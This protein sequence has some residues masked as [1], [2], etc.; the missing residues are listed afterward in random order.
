MPKPRLVEGTSVIIMALYNLSVLTE[1]TGR[2]LAEHA[3]G[4]LNGDD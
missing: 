2:T 3:V 4:W 1:S